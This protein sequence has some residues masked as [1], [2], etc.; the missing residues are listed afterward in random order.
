MLGGGGRSPQVR[1]AWFIAIA[2][3]CGNGSAADKAPPPPPAKPIDAVPP[4]DGA[5]SSFGSVARGQLQVADQAEHAIALG[6][7]LRD[8]N[9]ITFW[10]SWC[11]PCVDQL[12]M[13]ERL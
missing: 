11:L 2:F 12:P 3:G 5:V 6:A 4:V 7:R 8:A 9:V 10:A 13:V 1:R